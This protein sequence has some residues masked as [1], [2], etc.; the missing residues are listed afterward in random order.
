[1]PP[2]QAS[3]ASG[4]GEILFRNAGEA[5]FLADDRGSVIAVNSAL[6]SMFGFSAP[7]EML[8]RNAVSFWASKEEARKALED[9]LRSGGWMGELV[10][11]RKD[12]TKFHSHASASLLQSPEG[13]PCCLIGYFLDLTKERKIEKELRESATRLSFLSENLADGMVYQINSGRNGELRE[14]TYLSSAVER[15]HGLKREEVLKNPLLV[16]QQ[17][18]PEYREALSKRERDA[19]SSRSVMEM[20]VEMRLP[21]NEVRWRRFISA[22]RDLPDGTTVWDG[23]ELDIT[24]KQVAAREKER[25]KAQINQMQRLESIGHLAGG[26]AHDFNNMLGVIL[27]YTELILATTNPQEPLRGYLE[28]IRYAGRSSAELTR[29]LLGS[30]RMQAS[31]PKVLDLNSTVSGLLRML[32]HLAGEGIMVS[33]NPGSGLWPVRIDP[34]Q[35]DQILVNLIANARDAMEGTGQIT[36]STANLSSREEEKAAFPGKEGPGDFVELA[37]KDTGCGMPASVLEHIFEPFFSTKAD[38]HGTGLGLSTVY[39]IVQQ[40]GG[41]IDV[42][43]KSGMGTTF[44]VWFPRVKDAVPEPERVETGEALPGAGERILLVDDEPGSLMVA[45]AMLESLGY[46]VTAASRPK[47]AI[48]LIVQEGLRPDLLVTDLVMPEING[49]D[50]AGRVREIL[51]G[52]RC[53]FMSGYPADLVSPAEIGKAGIQFLAKPF[54]MRDLG[55]SVRKALTFEPGRDDGN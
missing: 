22:P 52:L 34:L 44:R 38:H 36:I 3:G 8:G 11:V 30:A 18:L 48:R 29:K 28:Q 16:Y 53:L 46:L 20:E 55:N 43:S 37:V 33:W 10:G 39:G 32:H 42:N 54:T 26:I 40:N 17:V 35:V 27:G 49:R 51:P 5:I 47:E 41:F 23:I 4:I 50:L 31:V 21:S 19:F 7:G 25:L 15:L 12:G 24:E 2:A 13:G 9:T 6:L 14:F 1:M 45:K